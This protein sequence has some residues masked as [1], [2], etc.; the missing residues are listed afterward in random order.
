M[1]PKQTCKHASIIF[2]PEIVLNII[3]DICS[4]N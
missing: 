3:E 4:I 2:I 1:I